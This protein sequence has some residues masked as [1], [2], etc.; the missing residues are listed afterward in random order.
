M[1]KKSVIILLLSSV[2]LMGAFQIVNAATIDSVTSDKATY[3]PGQKGY[4]TVAVSNEEANSIRVTELTAS[5][6]YYYED[7][8]VYAQTFY[9]SES[10]PVEV[11]AGDTETFQIPLSLPVNIASG[12]VNPVVAVRSE[13]WIL[14]D[15]RWRIAD[16]VT[17]SSLKLFVE[18]STTQSNMAL[19]LVL[20]AM[21]VAGV[22]GFLMYMIYTKKV[23]LSQPVAI[24]PPSQTENK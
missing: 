14:Q 7:G 11:S 1:N 23:R 21:V 24:V 13:R 3:F 6:S 17:D 10:L 15:L 4:I 2:V 18:S 19:V 20:V 8:T 9:A 16:R 5:I 22:V 12:Y